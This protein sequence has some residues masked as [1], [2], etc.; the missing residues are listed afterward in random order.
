MYFSL[1]NSPF[2]P[3]HLRLFIGEIRV[4]SCIGECGKVA[5]FLAKL[6]HVS[7]LDWRFFLRLY[8][9]Q[10]LV[11]SA[12]CEWA[13]ASG[14]WVSLCRAS[15]RVALLALTRGGRGTDDGDVTAS[16]IRAWASGASSGDAWRRLWTPC[17]QLAG[18]DWRLATSWTTRG[19]WAG[20]TGERHVAG[21][22]EGPGL[23]W[24]AG[25]S[26][27]LCCWA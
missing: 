12:V 4:E 27:G 21:R 18:V 23:V 16:R 5:I 26:F 14:E 9:C 13:T 22:E 20:C 11:A 7:R 10:N 15:G 2:F 6:G 19:G 8:T 3:L 24:A 25:P 1:L 17:S